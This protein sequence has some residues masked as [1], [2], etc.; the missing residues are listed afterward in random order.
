MK[1]FHLLFLMLVLLIPV[2][3]ADIS[4]QT[5]RD[6]YNLRNNIKVSASVLESSNF[7]G[8]F[9]LTII[10]SNYRLQYITKP[11]TLESNSRTAVSVEELPVTSSMLGKCAVT[12]TLT[13]TEDTI[14]EE[15][16]SNSFEV[17]SL[18]TVLPVNARIT[19]LPGDTIQ[20]AA[21][22]NEAYGSNVIK[23]PTKITLDS[24]IYPVDAADG[25]LNFNV[26][27]PQN[28]KSGL[29]SIEI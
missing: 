13:T 15:Q 14:V 2:S 22:V 6:I 29:H 26:V 7:E 16:D 18:L 21:V 12:G 3:L 23:A 25:R 10:C 8:L 5:Y 9:K 27:V 1:K 11:I 24:S 19:A 28:I 4:I 20:V 17:T